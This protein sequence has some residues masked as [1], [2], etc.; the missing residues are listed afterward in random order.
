RHRTAM[1]ACYVM[2]ARN[3]E[4]KPTTLR[5]A[6]SSTRTPYARINRAPLN[7]CASSPSSGSAGVIPT[8]WR[9]SERRTGARCDAES[10]PYRMGAASAARNAYEEYDVNPKCVCMYKGKERDSHYYAR[11]TYSSY[12][13]QTSPLPIVKRAGVRPTVVQVR[14]CSRVRSLCVLR[15]ACRWQCG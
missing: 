15:I 3:L 5:P 10:C 13:I 12:F 6:T 9:R 11:V 8:Q 7:W 4:L 1:L 14:P 2:Q